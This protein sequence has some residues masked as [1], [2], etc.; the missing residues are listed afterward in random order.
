MTS[1]GA[2][3]QT[4]LPLDM[5]LFTPS[6]LSAAQAKSLKNN[7]LL[8][9]GKAK[10]KAPKL[11]KPKAS[12]PAQPPAQTQV[13]PAPHAK[14]VKTGDTLA[15]TPDRR[16]RMRDWDLWGLSAPPSGA[17]WFRFGTDAVLLDRTSLEVLKVRPKALDF[18]DQ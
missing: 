2:T 16:M 14:T 13:T 3:L 11:A 5:A 17:A 4:A 8:V 18:E 12:A 1:T 15:G 6:T 7:R 9:E 10:S